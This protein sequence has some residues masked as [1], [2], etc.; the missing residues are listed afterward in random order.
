MV[1]VYTSPGACRAE[2]QQLLNQ[3]RLSMHQGSTRTVHSPCVC[4]NIHTWRLRHTLG[5][6]HPC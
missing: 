6:D 4:S 1:V 5:H 3:V 2:T